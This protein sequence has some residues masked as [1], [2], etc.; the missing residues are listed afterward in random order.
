MQSGEAVL[1]HAQRPRSPLRRTARLSAATRWGWAMPQ[2]TRT[3]SGRQSLAQ[4]PAARLLRLP[5]RRQML[6][7]AAQTTRPAELQS[8]LP[9][10]TARQPQPPRQRLAARRARQRAE[11]LLPA[12]SPPALAAVQAMQQQASAWSPGLPQPLMR[13]RSSRLR[14]MRQLQQTVQSLVP[15]PMRTLLHQ[16]QPRQQMPQT[17][18]C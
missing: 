9:M 13:R 10:L 17:K 7:P 5:R 3:Q 16:V 14:Q 18:V 4:A 8:E 12:L 11:V 6:P 1:A 15:Q 2:T